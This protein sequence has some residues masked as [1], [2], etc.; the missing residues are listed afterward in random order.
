MTFQKQ[1]VFYSTKEHYIKLCNE[2]TWHNNL[3]TLVAGVSKFPFSLD[4]AFEINFQNK[5]ERLAYVEKYKQTYFIILDNVPCQ[6]FL[7][8]SFSLNDG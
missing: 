3:T 2:L 5:V 7:N 4:L 8:Y 6:G 1:K